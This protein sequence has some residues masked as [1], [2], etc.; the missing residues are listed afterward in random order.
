MIALGRVWKLYFIYTILLV[1]GVALAGFV[2]EAQVKKRLTE[3]L[4]EDA[5]SLARVL[6]HSL[7][8]SEDPSVLDQFCDS[9]R[10]V[11]GTRITLLDRAGKVVGESD[12]D[13]VEVG[14]RLD[15]PEVQDAIKKGVGTGIRFSKTLRID[16]LYTAYF[17]KEKGKIIRIAVPMTKV[18]LFQNEVMILF[19][20]ALFLVPFFAIVVTFFFTKYGIYERAKKPSIPLQNTGGIARSELHAH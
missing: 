17:S 16:M 2:L 14:T 10:N 9:F 8:D 5:L 13:T 20:L 3:H 15:R 12:A 1:V 4:E 6:A 18:R 7:P 19:S 11:A